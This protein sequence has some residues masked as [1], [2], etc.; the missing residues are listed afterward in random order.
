MVRFRG[1]LAA[2]GLVLLAMPACNR[3]PVPGLARGRAVYATC[4]P[5]HGSDGGGN[6]TLGAPAIAGLPR[7]YVEAQ[8][9]N[10]RGG[11]RGSHPFDTVGLRMK[12]MSLAL[13]WE[14]DAGSVAEYVAS[15]P[16]VAQAPVLSGDARAGEAAWAVCAACHGADGSGNELVHA[17]PLANQADWYLVAQLEKFRRGWRGSNPADI[18]GQTM[19]ANTLSM[20]DAAI[21][22]VVAYI[23]TLRGGR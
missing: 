9:E 12:S 18:W 1:G 2:A 17:P 13:D 10:F 8:L 4:Q 20:D 15:L 23:Q 5:C 19:R 16:V 14:G 22:D 11:R 6:R 7:W 21:A 3:T